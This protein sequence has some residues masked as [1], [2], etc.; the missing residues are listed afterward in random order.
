MA[1]RKHALA[2]TTIAQFRG[3]YEREHATTR[4][5]LGAFPAEQGA[6][7]PHERSSS[8]HTLAWTFVVEEMMMLKALTNEP[9]FGGT[10]SGKPPESWD[11]V[12]QLFD[13]QHQRI[14][15]MLESADVA[16]LNVV[17]FM[18]GPKQPGDYAPMEF[19]WFMLFDQ[20]HHRG[21]LSVYLR[22]TG[23]KVPSI[24]GPSADEPW[25]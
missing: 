6:F 10:G 13:E 24:Y 21:Q 19:L 3:A 8:A 9:I 11:A 12:L 25:L 17:K 14:L 1:D 2:D 5:I 7:K 4:K 18:V 15:Q 23:E 16:S 22:M 20:I